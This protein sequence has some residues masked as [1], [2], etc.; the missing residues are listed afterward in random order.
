MNGYVS[1]CELTIFDHYAVYGNPRELVG[2]AVI[3][4]DLDS[5][6]VEPLHGKFS[7]GIADWKFCKGVR[8]SMLDIIREV[9]NA[10]AAS[11]CNIVIFT[12]QGGI[13]AGKTSLIEV[14]SKLESVFSALGFS[15]LTFI[16]MSDPWRK[17]SPLMFDQ[18]CENYM[19]GIGYNPAP[20][21]NP[22]GYFIGDAYSADDFSDSDYR[23]AVNTGL[24]FIPIRTFIN[25][26]ERGIMLS[27]DKSRIDYDAFD[28]ACIRIADI[29]KINLRAYLAADVVDLA[30]VLGAEFVCMMIGPPGCG[31]STYSANLKQVYP[32]SVIVN[33]DTLL[34]GG[35]SATAAQ[36]VRAVTNLIKTARKQIIIDATHPSIQSREPYIKLAKAA[37]IRV[38]AIMFDISIDVAKHLN[39]IRGICGGSFI[40][41]IA[42][43]V[44]SKNLNRPTREEGFD[45]VIFVTQLKYDGTIPEK[46]LDLI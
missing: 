20:R 36:C 12:N 26:W 2:N 9:F 25:T 37:G 32:N 16:A 29:A 33:R 44:Y 34:G 40:P 19:P 45:D 10:A 46:Y 39:W 13:T 27:A 14:V 42:Y 6:I 15:I 35:K 18:L 7:K 11:N 3:G 23:F 31:K 28:A 4:F 8:I 22:R 24:G 30:P 1:D 17:P 38:I 43:G 41:N 21:P 5:T